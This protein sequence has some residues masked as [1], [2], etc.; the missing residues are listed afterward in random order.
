MS[1]PPGVRSLLD[2]LDT[3]LANQ[4]TA[5]ISDLA[6]I[7]TLLGGAPPAGTV[8]LADIKTALEG[9][10]ADLN[11]NDTTISQQLQQIYLLLANSIAP[12]IE[13]CFFAIQDI[14]ALLAGNPDAPKVQPVPT[15]TTLPSNQLQEHC[16]RVQWMI[17]YYFDNWLKLV[18]D[19]TNLVRGVGLSIA[20]GALTLTG[21]G[22]IPLAGLGTAISAIQEC[23]T[24]AITGL[25]QQATSG[26]RAQ[27]RQALYSAT[28]A[29]QAYSL[30]ISTIDSMSGVNI[31]YRTAWKFLIWTSWFND[32]YNQAGK[33]STLQPGTWETAG[34][35]GTACDSGPITS[36]TCQTET[37]LGV[38]NIGFFEYQI[39]W[40]NF[41]DAPFIVGSF[42]GRPTI[43]A[44]HI[45]QITWEVTSGYG[46]GIEIRRVAQ[47]GTTVDGVNSFIAQSGSITGDFSKVSIHRWANRGGTFTIDICVTAS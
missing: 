27:L 47:D 17:D 5:L 34:Y 32:L 25:Y 4:H 33:N 31:A 1:N 20:I 2:A 21:F 37:T 40:I 36:T 38:D 24:L 6:Q 45:T 41:T 11:D 29:S 9:L 35:S 16:K 8:T 3:Q 22:A 18:S 23:Y 28:N 7:I 39:S 10:R 44:S 13:N 14:Y 26:V 46:D 12:N 15:T 19:T 42:Q 30:W 43:E